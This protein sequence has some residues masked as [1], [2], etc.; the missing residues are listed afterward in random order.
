[1]TTSKKDDFMVKLRKTTL[2]PPEELVKQMVYA[3]YVYLG[4]R[5]CF[6][7]DLKNYFVNLK[8]ND[9]ALLSQ[10]LRNV[11]YDVRRAPTVKN[12]LVV[13]NILAVDVPKNRGTFQKML[14]EYS[15]IFESKRLFT[16]AKRLGV[17]DG[18]ALRDLKKSLNYL[19]LAALKEELLR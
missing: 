13:Q 19:Q 12:I 18:K 6:L 9:Y 7:Y 11:L 15:E 4:A 10:T 17:I 8:Y 16:M 3:Q 5:D 2:P 1:M 14:F